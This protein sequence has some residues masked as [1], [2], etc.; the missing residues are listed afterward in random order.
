[1]A[2][3]GI[4]MNIKKIP[5]SYEITQK[6]NK[7][8]RTLLRYPHA[9]VKKAA[10]EIQKLLGVSNNIE[11]DACSMALQRTLIREMAQTPSLQD[12]TLLFSPLLRPI[13]Y[14]TELFFFADIHAAISEIQGLKTLKGANIL[15]LAPSWGPYMHYL[16]NRY[17]A[18]TYGVDMN[19]V[20]VEYANR[21]H[22]NFKVGDASKMG[23]FQDNFFDLVISLNFL[24]SDYL[25]LFLND[26][27]T[28]FMEKVLMEVHRVLKPGK[29]FLSQEEETERLLPAVNLFSAFKKIE[30]P[31]P[32]P[33]IILQK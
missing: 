11:L 30:F 13:D 2:M 32:G 24:D 27:T 8:R 4:S 6:A 33:I 16:H 25:Q 1:M 9:Y 28:S 26:K 22:L 23:F 29:L 18:K 15:Q 7:F 14:N 31:F 5:S 20:S 21:G 17:G 10:S 3:D 12:N 19:K